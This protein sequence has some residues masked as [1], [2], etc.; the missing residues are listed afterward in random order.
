MDPRELLKTYREDPGS[1]VANLYD[2]G[3][4]RMTPETESTPPLH[5]MSTCE[6]MRA[7]VGND[8]W[9]ESPALQAWLQK[10][11]E[12][13]QAAAQA[14]R[15]GGRWGRHRPPGRARLRRVCRLLV[16]QGK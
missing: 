11:R 15:H 13:I 1:L 6:A 16:H 3:H 2:P 9:R 8:N 10:G 12:V 4:Y 5:T 7:L 14:E